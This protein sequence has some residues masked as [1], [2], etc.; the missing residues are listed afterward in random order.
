MSSKTAGSVNLERIE[1]HIS[2]IVTDLI[3]RNPKQMKHFRWQLTRFRKIFI[4]KDTVLIIFWLIY[5]NK[6]EKRSR[7]HIEL[8]VSKVVGKQRVPGSNPSWK[9]KYLRQFHPRYGWRWGEVWPFATIC[10]MAM[11]GAW[12]ICASFSGTLGEP[13]VV[14]ATSWIPF[15]KGNHGPK[16]ASRWQSYQD[17]RHEVLPSDPRLRHGRIPKRLTSS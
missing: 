11:C 13:N 15:W 16:I 14:L 1:K 4:S 10:T 5:A 8:A 2:R 17:V 6:L 7:P 3:D 12:G 9:N